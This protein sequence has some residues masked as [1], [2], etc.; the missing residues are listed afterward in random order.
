M[1]HLKVNPGKTPSP[2]HRELQGPRSK[3]EVSRVSTWQ[4]PLCLWLHED[5]LVDTPFLLFPTYP[6][7][8]LRL[9]V[10][11]SWLVP[12]IP[13]LPLFRQWCYRTSAFFDSSICNS[14]E[15]AV[16]FCCW[17]RAI[18]NI[19]PPS[20]QS[21][22]SATGDLLLFCPRRPATENAALFGGRGCFVTGPQARDDGR[23][24][25]R[26]RAGSATSQGFIA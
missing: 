4:E 15:A 6:S 16:F 19:S 8:P 23:E 1:I 9:Y 22:G 10:P 18:R 24:F 13:C 12:S 2:P 3:V 5:P 25:F 21:S 11:L 20:R 26:A 17:R 7:Q 14:G